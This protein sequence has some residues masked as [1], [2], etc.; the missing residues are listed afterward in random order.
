MYTYIIYSLTKDRQ[1]KLNK[2]INQ[3]YKHNKTLYFTHEKK[4]T[5]AC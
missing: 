5:T 1:M 3:M 4:L 2:Y